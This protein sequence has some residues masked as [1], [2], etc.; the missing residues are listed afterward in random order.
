MSL[1]KDFPN[2]N[3]GAVFSLSVKGLSNTQFTCVADRY[4][5]G[6][7]QTG[8]LQPA[9][10]PGPNVFTLAEKGDYAFIVDLLF[11]SSGSCE[12]EAI[13]GGNKYKKTVDTKTQQSHKVRLTVRVV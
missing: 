4:F 5:N 9:F 3:Q 13:V 7:K 12:V 11:L 10:S 2:V 1:F 8:W 6:Q